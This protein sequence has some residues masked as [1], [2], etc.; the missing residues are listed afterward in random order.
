MSTLTQLIRVAAPLIP[1][2]TK[3][4]EALIEGDDEKAEEAKI[5]GMVRAKYAGLRQARD[6]RS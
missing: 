5:E 4:I 6:A 1:A 2:V 3:F